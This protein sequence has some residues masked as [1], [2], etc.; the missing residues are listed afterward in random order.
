MMKANPAMMEM[1]QKQMPGVDQATMAKGLEWL[2][3]L[4]KYYAK[5]RNF[6]NNKFVQLCLILFVISIIFYFFGR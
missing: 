5:T 4:A 1:L 6:F 3:S 2:A